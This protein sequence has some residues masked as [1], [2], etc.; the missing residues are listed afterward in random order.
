MIFE[1][2]QVTELMSLA[3]TNKNLQLVVEDVLRR[4]FAKKM[5]VFNG[6]YST[7]KTATSRFYLTESNNEIQISHYPT[8]LKMLKKFSHLISKLKVMHPYNLPA[9]NHANEIYRLINLHCSET[10]TEL[11]MINKE[12]D[13]FGELT[14][15]FKRVEHVSLSGNFHKLSNHFNEIFPSTQH[16]TLDMFQTDDLQWFD[17]KIPHLES[18]SFYNWG[19]SAKKVEIGEQMIRKM[20]KA[21]PQIQ[22]FSVD[23]AFPRLLK[24][25]EDELPM[26]KNLDITSYVES[27]KDNESYQFLFEHLKSFKL[28]I[29]SHSLPSN[30]T[31]THLEEFVTDAFSRKCTRWIEFVENEKN[32]KKLEVRRCLTDNEIIRLTKAELNLEEIYIEVEKTVDNENIVKF[33]ESLQGLR[34]LHIYIP[35]LNEWQAAVDVLHERF[36]SEWTIDV[37]MHHI[38]VRRMW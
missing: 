26:L 3:D 12:F 36:A 38:V 29:S 5:I 22:S 10:L 34:K 35:W 31:F 9:K 17:C 37:T 11:S 18:L 16:L 19:S 4:R 7:S 14:D 6:P 28:M 20:F 15:S 27:P 30:I 21:N 2:L 1:R 33:I 25:V 23:Y 13:I 8:V 24:R 32:L